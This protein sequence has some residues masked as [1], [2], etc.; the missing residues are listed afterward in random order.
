MQISRVPRVGLAI[1]VLA[2]LAGCGTLVGLDR[3]AL[4][5]P[6]MSLDAYPVDTTFTEEL[7]RSREAASGGRRLT[8]GVCGCK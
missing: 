1:V 6:E 5:R 3:T 4:A 7:Y 2:G 8:P